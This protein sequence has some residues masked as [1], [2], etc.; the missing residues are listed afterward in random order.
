MKRQRNNVFESSSESESEPILKPIPKR[1]F[2]PPDESKLELENVQSR[3]NDDYMKYPFDDDSLIKEEIVQPSLKTSIIN[4]N[5]SSS[6]SIGLS[7]M[8]K[9]G[10]TIGTSLGKENSTALLEPISIEVKTDNMGLGAPKK[11]ILTD[12]DY[13]I[14]TKDRIDNRLTNKNKKQVNSIMKLCF[15]L[16][17]EADKFHQDHIIDNVNLL[18]REYVQKFILKEKI[19][20]Y[21]DYDDKLLKL[22]H[23]L[24]TNHNYCWYCGCSYKDDK[25]LDDFC[26]GSLETDHA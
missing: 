9:M 7:I 11:I 24:R 15:E 4:Q 1:S 21:D 16:S 2:K 6:K 22:I 8:E 14:Y 19:E 26:P 20:D 13:S 12:K 10:Y 3:S 17:G 5:K 25:D 18:W 23:Y